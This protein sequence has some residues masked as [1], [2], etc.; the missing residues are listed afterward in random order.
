MQRM[1]LA[2]LAFKPMARNTLRG[3]ADVRV[4]KS[5]LIKEVPVHVS[6]GKAWASLPSKPVLKDGRVAT[7]ERG[8]ARYV[9]ILEWAD[10]DAR[11]AFSE[12]VV[13]AVRAQAPDAVEV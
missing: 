2:L 12:A 4:G 8:K 11:D 6:N 5:L 10:K 7:D 3:F 9:P 1:P 13:E